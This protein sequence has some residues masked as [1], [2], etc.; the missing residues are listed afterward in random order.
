MDREADSWRYSSRGVHSV[1]AAG[2][3]RFCIVQ[4]QGITKAGDRRGDRDPY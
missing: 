1:S 3:F 4:G 2:N